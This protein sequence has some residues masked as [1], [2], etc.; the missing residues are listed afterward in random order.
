VQQLAHLGV[1]RF[2]LIDPDIVDKTNL[3]R[4]VGATLGDGRPKVLVARR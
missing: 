2:L 4:M 3:N 1:R